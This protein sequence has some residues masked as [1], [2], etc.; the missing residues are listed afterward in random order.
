MGFEL[1]PADV[2]NSG[3]TEYLEAVVDCSEDLSPDQQWSPSDGSPLLASGRLPKGIV[4]K[5]DWEKLRRFARIW[6][7]GRVC[8]MTSR[9]VFS[10]PLPIR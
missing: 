6:H 4:H 9:K 2:V 7:E 1:L 8:S 10:D 3:L 5:V